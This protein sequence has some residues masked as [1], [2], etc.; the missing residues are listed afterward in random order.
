MA[1]YVLGFSNVAEKK[2]AMPLI[3][4]LRFPAKWPLP[5]S[6]GSKSAENENIRWLDMEYMTLYDII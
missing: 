2:I 1:R 6:F 3:P 4:L 5:E